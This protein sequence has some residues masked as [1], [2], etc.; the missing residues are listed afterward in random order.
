MPDTFTQPQNNA[1]HIISEVH[2]GLSR[3]VVGIVAS[4]TLKA[5]AVLG[6]V[7]SS[8]LYKEHDP[9]ASDGSEA[10]NSTVVLLADVSVGSGGGTAVVT[11]R[12]AEVNSGLLVWKSGMTTNQKN[13]AIAGLATRFIIARTGVVL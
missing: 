10:V 4:T 8:G 9:A 1:E 13:A 11:A 5:G 7:T 2:M 12:L 3:D 6:R